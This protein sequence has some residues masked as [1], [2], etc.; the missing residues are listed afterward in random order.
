MDL[1]LWRHAEAEEGVPDEARR[2]TSKGRR[3]ALRVGTWLRE[4]VPGRTRLLTSPA[5]RAQETAAAFG[6]EAQI[7]ASLAPGASARAILQTAG[8]PHGNGTV[9]VVGHQP[10]LG[11][12]ASLI[13]SGKEQDWNLKKG[14]AWWFRSKAS[15]LRMDVA[16]V[17]VVC[18]DVV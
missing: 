9:I 11:R 7:V 13:L 12:A 16:L 5:R 1:I 14:A 10:D 8:W 4:R 3:Q 15:E 17:A 18:P 2:L 6:S